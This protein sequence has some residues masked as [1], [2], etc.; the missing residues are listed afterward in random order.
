MSRKSAFTLLELSIVLVI[1]GL[2]VGGVLVGT[3][4]IKSAKLQKVI[5]ESQG[6]ANAAAT[7]KLKYNGIPGDMPNPEDYFPDYE[8]NSG[9]MD[10]N[11][12]F[13]Y[14]QSEGADAWKQLSLAGLIGASVQGANEYCGVT[15][16]A[17][18]SCSGGIGITSP[19]SSFSDRATW[20]IGVSRQTNRNVVLLG[21]GPTGDQAAWPHRG[22]L[23]SLG[24]YNID[25][26]IDD[27]MPYS[28][29]VRN[30]RS[31]GSNLTGVADWEYYRCTDRDN[32]VTT[33]NGGNDPADYFKV[34]GE[35]TC[36]LTFPLG[37]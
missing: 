30:E 7:F 8:W 22:I 33:K 25:S 37:I 34:D 13:I 29:S 28:G 2:V 16:S 1:I 14:G 5:R 15:A 23:T 6:Y 10:I 12:G 18:E 20:G 9:S 31:I 21:A 4:L 17:P 3:D 24:A 27:G 35:P 26:K 36:S 19:R 32:N 11:S